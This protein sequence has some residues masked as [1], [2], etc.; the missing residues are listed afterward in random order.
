MHE[1]ILPIQA[2][3]LL[4]SLCGEVKSERA[5]LQAASLP[6]LTSGAPVAVQTRLKEHGAQD[7]PDVYTPHTFQKWGVF[8]SSTPHWHPSS[9]STDAV[10]GTRMA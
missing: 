3:L 8:V 7:M 6:T 1:N 2:K 5:H 9:T 10:A 4:V